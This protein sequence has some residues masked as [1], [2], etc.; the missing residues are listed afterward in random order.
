MLYFISG[1]IHFE[2]VLLH[3]IKSKHTLWIGTADINDLYISNGKAF[4]PFHW[5]II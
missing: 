1:I 2:E 4:L 5:S 3:A